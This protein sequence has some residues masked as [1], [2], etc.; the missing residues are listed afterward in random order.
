MNYFIE[1]WRV[2][3]F[4]K[5]QIAFQI[6]LIYSNYVRTQLHLDLLAKL[7]LH[8]IGIVDNHGDL[9]GFFIEILAQFIK[10][11]LVGTFEAAHRLK[12]LMA[13]TKTIISSIKIKLHLKRLQR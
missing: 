2:L 8:Y 3:K 11:I 10:Y 5:L 4:L 1:R 13:N 12:H 9:S 6:C 7:V